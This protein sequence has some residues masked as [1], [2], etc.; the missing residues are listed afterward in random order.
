MDSFMGNFGWDYNVVTTLQGQITQDSIYIVGGHHDCIALNS[1]YEP[2]ADDNASG[3]AVVLETARVLKTL[4]YQP[5]STI[6]FITFAAEE[7]GLWGSEYYATVARNN[8]LRIQLMI[9][10]DN[11]ANCTDIVNS[12]IADIYDYPN[13]VT[14]QNIAHKAIEQYTTLDYSQ[15]APPVW[16]DSR[17]F[18]NHGYEA[19]ALREHELSPFYHTPNDL[20]SHCNMLYATEMAKISCAM[21]MMTN[22]NNIVNPVPDDEPAI[23]SGITLYQNYPNPFNPSTTIDYT[24]P[25]YGK[26]SIKVYDMLGREVSEL[27]N[28]YKTAGKHSVSWNASG[29]ASG[30]YIYRITINKI[31][32]SRKMLLLK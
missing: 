27:V 32:T 9:N 14:V 7:Y 1:A 24:I 26:V 17:S 28:E 13:S 2:G 25:S 21:L 16:T 29:V 22:G 8:N 19:I 5:G 12:W 31:S 15:Y 6:K 23:P 3:T 11:V 4:N 30:I 18:N 20:L 10:N